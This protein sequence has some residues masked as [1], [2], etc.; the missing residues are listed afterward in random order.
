MF[1]IALSAQRE[2]CATALECYK[3]TRGG[4]KVPIG[5]ATLEGKLKFNGKALSIVN[6]VD[7]SCPRRGACR[8]CIRCCVL[9]SSEKQPCFAY[10]SRE[11]EGLE[12]F[13]SIVVVQEVYHGQGH[14]ALK[15]LDFVLSTHWL[16]LCGQSKSISTD[17]EY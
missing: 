17:V 10:A 12:L 6:R 4:T 11:R 7:I 3:H 14:H 1:S 5:L 13:F 2:I 15:P 9:T 8:L 16:Q